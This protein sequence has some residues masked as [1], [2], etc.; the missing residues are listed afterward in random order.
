MNH[1]HPFTSPRFQAAASGEPRLSAP[2]IGAG[3]R[4]SRGSSS[5][6]VPIRVGRRK[7]PSF[8]PPPLD[9][10]TVSRL[11]LGP[12]LR[13]CVRSQSAVILAASNHGRKEDPHHDEEMLFVALKQQ[14]TFPKDLSFI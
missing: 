11:P 6:L 8:P 9:C 4:L 10:A 7:W 3:R 5:G 12:P 13:L 14:H 1:Y 2:L